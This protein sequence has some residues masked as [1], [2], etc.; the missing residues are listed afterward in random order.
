MVALGYDAVYAIYEALLC[1][2]EDGAQIS[3]DMSA[4]DFGEILDGVFSGGFEFEALTGGG[5]ADRGTVKWNSDG[6]ISKK[7]YPVTIKSYR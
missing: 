3:P 7:L 6:T 2:I 4:D 1:A 5:G